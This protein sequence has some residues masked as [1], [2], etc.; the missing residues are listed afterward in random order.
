M[1]NKSF[2]LKNTLITTALGMLSFLLSQSYAAGIK[3]ERRIDDLE[4]EVFSYQV[5]NE[6]IR[7]TL[8]EIKNDIKILKKEKSI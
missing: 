7:S 1:S 5:H 8:T 6:W 3:L 4:K 2:P